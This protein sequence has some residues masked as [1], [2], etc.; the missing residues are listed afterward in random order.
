MIDSIRYKGLDNYNREISQAQMVYYLA[1][2]VV[3]TK[4]ILAYSEIIVIPPIMNSVFNLTFIFL[5]LL[6]VLITFNFKLKKI[7]LIFILFVVMSVYKSIQK[8]NYIMFFS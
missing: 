2:I 5:I 8:D 1:T 6:K 3:V 7:Y 4:L